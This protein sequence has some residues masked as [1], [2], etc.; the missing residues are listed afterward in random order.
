MKIA[1][2]IVLSDEERATLERWSRG[3][4]TP[5]RLVLRSQIVL[6]AAEGKMNQEIAPRLKTA[7]KTV[8]LWRRRFA[9]RRVAG[10]EKDAPR[11]GRPKTGKRMARL[12][13]EKTTQERPANAT[14]WSTRTL[15]KYLGTSRSMVQRVWKANGLK[16][17]LTRTFKLTTTH[18]S[19]RN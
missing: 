9:E 2:E 19:W 1:P 6:L 13:V 7:L 15:A 11:G 3:R 14:H 8:S 12:I 10:I 17:H 16:P 5:A 18:A 4:S